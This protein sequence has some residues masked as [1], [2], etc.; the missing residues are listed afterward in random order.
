ME[1]Q[2]DAIIVG[3]SSVGATLALALGR[4]GMR[5]ALIDA[6]EFEPSWPAGSVDLRVFA[7]TRASQRIFEHL[8]AWERM[9]EL[10]VS[11][12]RAMQVWDA[13][14]DGQ[15]RFDSAEIAEPTLGHIIE[16]RVIQQALL[17]AIDGVPAITRICPAEIVAF[18]RDDR[19]MQVTLASGAVLS[20]R[21]LVGADGADSSLRTLAGIPLEVQPY[22]QEAVVGVVQTELPHRETAWQRF[23]PDGPL[24]FLPLADGRCSIVWSTTP[25]EAERLCDMPEENFLSELTMAFASRLGRVT[26]V[27]ERVRFPLRRQHAGHYVEP[28]LALVG[29]AAHV[30]HP[31][32]GQGVNLGL[33]DAA[34]LAEVLLSAR[35]RGQDWGRLSV[36]RRYERWRR[37][38]NQ[39]MMTAMDGFKQ[40]FG[41][42]LPPLRVARNLG[43]NLV[44]HAGPVKDVIVKHAM[45]L[46]GDLPGLAR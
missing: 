21:L 27:G 25:P 38:E 28:G 5:V 26:G 2:F 14:G 16:Q 39:L 1:T 37:G 43:L 15:I 9:V 18:Q 45:G 44:D 30:I 20:G 6:S 7:I 34:T 36:L 23:L 42:S 40:L 12:F 8:E 19:V 10:G 46:S 32:A 22:H 11:P 4:Q 3:G 41:S 35:A 33:L 29:D 17:E 24:A 13:R 31:L